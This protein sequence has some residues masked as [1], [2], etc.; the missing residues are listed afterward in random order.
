MSHHEYRASAPGTV[1]PVR[2]ARSDRKV[3]RGGYLSVE[4]ITLWVVYALTL[5][6][7]AVIEG[8]Q[9][10]GTTS[11]TVAYGV[12]A[13]FTPAGYVFAIWSLIYVALIVWLVAYTRTAPARPRRF[14]M[15]SVLFIASCVCN[16]VWLLLWHFQMIGVSFAVILV[17]WFIL[18]ALYLDIRRT[19]K[20]ASGRVP[21]AIYTAWITVATLCNMV[22]LVTRAFDGGTPFFN[23]LFTILLTV[24]VLAFGYVMRKVCGDIAFPLVFL[25]AL[26]GVG[27]HV[28]KVSVPT[29]VVV[30]V[31]CGVGAI[32]TFASLGS[33]K[34]PSRG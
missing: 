5:I 26:V 27:V 6:G 23:G 28:L 30:F 16:V 15:T 4:T 21:I 22:I 19:A 14:T 20:T 31:L 33:M 24:G 11:A 2:N 12:F 17:M 25:W 13:W 32:L 8:G 10:G 18:G 9:V 34:K 1:Q 29:A 3:E 7:N